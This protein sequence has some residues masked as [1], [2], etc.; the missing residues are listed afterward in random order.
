MQKSHIFIPL[1]LAL[2]FLQSCST[3]S[4]ENNKINSDLISNAATASSEVDLENVPSFE[5]ENELHD[6]GSITQG[7]KVSYSF[8]FKNTGKK[9]LIISSAN[10]SCGCTVPQYPKNPIAPGESASIDVVFNSE[11][12]EGKQDKSVTLMANTNPA[13]KVLKISGNVIVP[14]S[15]NN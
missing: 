8:K 15:N 7:E 10:G 2:G 5:F 9:N 14:T 1:M 3:Q 4:E 6:F 12:K 13:S 11:G